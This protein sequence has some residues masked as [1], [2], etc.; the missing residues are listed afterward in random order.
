V[1][2]LAAHPEIIEVT[3]LPHEKSNF[4]GVWHSDTTYLDEPPMGSML[5]ALEVTAVRRRY[6]FANMFLAYERLSDGMKRLLESLR[7]GEQLRESGRHPHARGP[8][9]GES[10]QGCPSRVRGHAIR[11]CGRI[12]SRGARRCT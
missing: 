5:Y 3:K 4:G 6:A 10:R 8:R 1:E 12:P 11:P 2:G 9:R 7:S